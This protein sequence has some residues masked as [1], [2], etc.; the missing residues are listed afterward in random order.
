M[1][2]MYAA[3]WRV[4]GGRQMVLIVLSLAIAALAAVPLN[5]QKDIIN[6]LTAADIAPS[7]LVW[8]CAGMMS[9]ILL[10]LG[11]KWVMGYRSGVLGEDIIRLLR[12]RILLGAVEAGGAL[13]VGTKST[14]ISAEAEELGKFAGNAMSQPVMQIGT[15]IS[16]VA[17]IATTQPGLGMIAVCMIV[18]QIIIVVFTQQYVNRFVARRVQILRGATDHMTHDDLAGIM[19]DVNREFD[20]IYETRRRM[21][22]WK[23]TTKFAVSAI[24]GVGSVSVLLLGGWFVIEGKTDVGTVVAAT[25]G[26]G[27][28]QGPT[29]FIISFYRLVS[30]T[31]VKY[32]LLR[33]A[34]MTLP[35]QTAAA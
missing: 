35:P 3:I 1:L 32:E 13:K 8:L 11:L 30:S 7:D 22:L 14:M 25:I 31:R 9:A 5:F 24:N 16:V 29:A 21:F 18:P 34:G 10:S 4:S 33:D 15:L 27:R 26:L 2:E 6:A 19:D 23:L 28:L 20:D 12:R 17:F